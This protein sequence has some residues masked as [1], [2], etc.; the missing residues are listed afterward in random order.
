MSDPNQPIQTPPTQTPPTQTPPTQIPLTQNPPIQ[1]QPVQNQPQ[2]YQGVPY[3][4]PYGA[5]PEHPQGT[6]ILVLGIVGF[7]ATI[8]APIAW[9]LGSKAQKEIAASGQHYSNEQNINIGKI[10]GMV[11]SILALAGIVI[12]IVVM[13]IMFIGFGAF[14]VAN[15]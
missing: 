4:Q 7:F 1:S 3:P 5:L 8:C 11:L 13:I 9:Y 15:Q 12:T 14:S 2:P 10:M 6:V